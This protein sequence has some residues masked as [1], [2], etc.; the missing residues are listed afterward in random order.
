MTF[1]QAKDQIAERD[2]VRMEN[3][4]PFQTYEV[5]H[6]AAELYADSV[7][8]ELKLALIESRKYVSMYDFPKT[9]EEHTK[10]KNELLNRIDKLLA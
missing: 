10:I 3:L 7:A 1:E 2:N 8:R 6:E 4:T 5:L 9:W